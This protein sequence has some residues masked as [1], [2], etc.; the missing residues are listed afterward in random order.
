MA[1]L[2]LDAWKM[3]AMCGHA[4]GL[5]PGIKDGPCLAPSS[6]PETPEPT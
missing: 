1:I 2:E 5:P 4:F 6:P 3:G